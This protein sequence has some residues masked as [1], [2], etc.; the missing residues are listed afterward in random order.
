MKIVT[1]TKLIK[2]NRKIGQY[3]TIAAML[4]LVAGLYV[5]Y[6]IQTNLIYGLGLTVV[7]FFLFQ[8]STYFVNRWGR[9]PRPDEVINKNMKG[10]GREYT[11][12]HY[13]TPASHLLVGPAGL[14][15]LMPYYQGGII[16]YN[17]KRWR[18]KGGGFARSYLR[19][20]G[21]ESMG[22]PDI[23]SAAEIQ[24]VKRFLERILP[25]GTEVPEI[26][27]AL[28]FTDPKVE[29]QFEATPIPALKPDGL[30]DFLKRAA[31]EKP[32]TELALSALRAALP[33]AE[34]DE[35]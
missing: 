23:E 21:Q 15:L 32:I 14:W 20:F 25:Q 2:R 17:G 10:M 18:S 11:V 31:K 9:F 4:M 3:T 24:A 29:L 35:G 34:K 6:K 22:R 7:G 12:Y 8:I 13:T 27:A 33:K 1:N 16:T 26:R 19:L 28:L 5:F 30:K